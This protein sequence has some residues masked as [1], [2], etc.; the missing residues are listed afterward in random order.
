MLACTYDKKVLE[1]KSTIAGK[2]QHRID[3]TLDG[4]SVD[5]LF[6][7]NAHAEWVCCIQISIGD[8]INQAYVSRREMR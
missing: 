6:N 1:H 4:L 2:N 5:L 3:Y 8:P 7:Y